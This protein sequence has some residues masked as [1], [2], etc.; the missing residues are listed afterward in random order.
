MLRLVLPSVRYKKTYLAAHKEF[1]LKNRHAGHADY[2]D[3]YS[4]FPLFVK[5]LRDMEKG[6]GLPKGYVPQTTYWLMDGKT[7]IGN[8]NIRHRLNNYLQKF[9]GHIGYEI[10]PSQRRQ[11]YGTKILGLALGKAK[12]MRIEKIFVMCDSANV[13]S[14]KIIEYNGGVFQNK[15]RVAGQKNPKLRFW[16]R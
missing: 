2:S 11:G 1:G 9:G 12:K 10:R 4:D 16:I 14:R 3:I 13:A 7:F 15:V 5:K 6:K 8:V